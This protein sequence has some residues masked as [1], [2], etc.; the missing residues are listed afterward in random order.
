M[1]GHQSP[2]SEG[3]T[4]R[5]KGF[6]WPSSSVLGYIGWKASGEVDS[7]F[8]SRALNFAGLLGALKHDTC[9]EEAD[10]SNRS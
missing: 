3:N 10:T 6:E 9:G 4:T 5:Q 7:I 1:I 2:R 8:F